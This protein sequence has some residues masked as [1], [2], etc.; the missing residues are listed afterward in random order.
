MEFGKNA[1]NCDSAPAESCPNDRR[2]AEPPKLAAQFSNCLHW[3]LNL[4]EKG[5]VVGNWPASSKIR[6]CVPSNFHILHLL[7]PLDPAVLTVRTLYDVVRS[8]LSASA[9]LLADVAEV[10]EGL[11]ARL[12]RAGR[13]V[14]YVVVH[15]V[16]KL[17]VKRRLAGGGG[18]RVLTVFRNKTRNCSKWC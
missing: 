5:V 14:R 11:V 3:R 17:H 15:G 7:R 6:Y 9:Q 18:V 12:D 16:V 1:T 4:P 10:L 8:R 13:R 2:N